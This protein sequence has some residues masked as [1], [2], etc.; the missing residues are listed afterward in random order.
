M[1]QLLLSLLLALSASVA[2]ADGIQFF[3]G[4]VADALKEA[5]RQGK[6]VFVDV[7]TPWCAPCKVMVREIFPR[8]EVGDFFNR[9]FINVKLDAEDEDLNGPELAEQ[10]GVDSYPTYLFLSPDGEVRHRRGGAMTAAELVNLG[11]Q[12]LGEGAVDFESLQARY[13][14][15]ERDPEFVR[16]FLSYKSVGAEK[17]G[18]DDVKALLDYIQFMDSA[19]NEYF[20]TQSSDQ[21]LTKANFE[22]IAQYRGGQPNID[23]SLI[24]FVFDNYPAYVTQAGEMPVANLIVKVNNTAIEQAAASGDREKAQRY[25]GAIKGELANAY[26]AYQ[27]YQPVADQYQQMSHLMQARLAQS[28]SNWETYMVQMSSYLEGEG[29]S[30]GAWKWFSVGSD[31]LRAAEDLKL[32]KQ[33]ERFI[34]VGYEQGKSAHI[35]MTYAE[36]AKQ[37]GD[38]VKAKSLYQEAITLFKKEYGEDAPILSSLNE[39]LKSL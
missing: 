17:L 18:K 7:Y 29:E 22:L 6:L 20:A 2:S 25:L 14:Q 26:L 3:N 34:R 30:A 9:H 19:A 27:R 10:Y 23:D 32:L 8:D 37:L 38:K 16:T 21:L 28:E 13:Q 12:A 15:G 24:Q 4:S 31:V 1:K 5:E 35:V 39:T 36:L 33:A 11:K